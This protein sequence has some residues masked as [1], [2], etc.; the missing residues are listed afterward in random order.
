M[1][2]NGSD[3]RR[4]GE[5]P[6]LWGGEGL[7]TGDPVPYSMCMKFP[8]YESMDSRIAGMQGDFKSGNFCQSAATKT[9]AGRPGF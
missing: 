4:N 1:K 2:K 3:G 8:G 6:S 9:V 5:Y 7:L